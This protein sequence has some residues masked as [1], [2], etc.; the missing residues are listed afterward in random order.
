MKSRVHM[1]AGESAAK[2]A[3]T[4]RVYS[5]VTEKTSSRRPHALLENDRLF[6]RMAECERKTVVTKKKKKDLVCA[7]GLGYVADILNVTCFFVI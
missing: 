1:R 7:Y 2:K 6:S 5:E 3:E 4:A